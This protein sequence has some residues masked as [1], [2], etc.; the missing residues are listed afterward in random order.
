MRTFITLFLLLS[1]ATSA[2]PLFSDPLFPRVMEY[3]DFNRD[4]YFRLGEY[5]VV[6]AGYA[7]G[8]WETKGGWDV[9]TLPHSFNEANTFTSL[10][11]YY[12]GIG[13]Y[14][15]HFQVA[16]DW[17]S[18]Q[19][20]LRFGAAYSVADV[21]VNEVYIGR[22]TGGFTPIEADVTH[23]VHA[24]DNLV[25][26]KVSNAHDPD[27]LPGKDIPDYCL[28]GGLYREAALVVKDKL[29]IVQDG[30]RITT[31]Q[32]SE[33][34]ATAQIEV[35]IRNDYNERK[36]GN[37]MVEI[38]D[39]ENPSFLCKH[40]FTLEAGKETVVTLSPDAIQ[41]PKLWSLEEPKRYR[42]LVHLYETGS[43]SQ[44]DALVAPIDSMTTQAPAE[45]EL[46]RDITDFGFRWFEFKANEGFFLNGKRVK[47][48]GVNRHQD[49]PGLANALP[50]WM[51]ERDAR[52]IKEAGANF[53]RASHYPQHPAFLN[54]CDRLGILVYEEICSWQYVGGAKFTKNAEAM[55][56]AM[57]A[58]DI[59]HPSIIVWGLF[60][61][62]RSLDLFERLHGIAS[63]LD[64]ARPTVYAENSPD[65]GLKLGTTGVPEVLGL[66]YS[67]EKLAE[68]H[69]TLPDKPLFSSEYAAASGGTR[70]DLER[71]LSQIAEIKK[72]LDPI[73]AQPFMAGHTLWSMHDY[74]TDYWGG[75]PVHH[76]GV[77]DAWRLPK[78]G[79]F[80][81]QTRWQ[82]K[83]VVHICGHWTWPG[84]EGKTRT[85]TVLSNCP[86]VELFLNGT[87]L[88]TRT[89]ENPAQWE[90]PYAPGE[91]RAVGNNADLRAEDSLRTA[92]APATLQLECSAPQLQAGSA[93]AVEITA[94]VLDAAGV[95][96]PIN[97]TPVTF[98]VE[99]PGIL[100]GVGGAPSCTLEMGIGRMILQATS[101]PATLTV[102][103]V[104]PTGLVATSSVTVV[105]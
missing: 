40:P 93:D 47:L 99:T 31:P 3:K 48:Q 104:T 87:S 21:W 57:I 12:R 16:E 5:D 54:A 89:T 58:R 22:Y 76:S 90:V 36:N 92:G 91:L 83:P 13:W 52:M 72:Q 20:F 44:K 49:Y 15:K 30:I 10:R 96:V 61:E 45:K 65:E 33:A 86:N 73:E 59:N 94:K 6:K 81:M 64:P 28:Y 63:K 14:R 25:A 37:C 32:V 82:A 103:A 67:T 53:V 84:E 56:R 55:M 101:A 50:Q 102:K 85:V 98:S 78:D 62:G 39:G 42:V 29:H 70:K 1:A 24:G 43:A 71:Q 51:Q 60:N 88:G 74:S 4:W 26:V 9:V 27:V 68:I 38:A 77:L 7:A 34:E 100:R 17:T 46:D 11:G 97:D 80:Y 79:W 75:W 66:N 35:H 41:H 19:I 95:V 105:E 8:N 18:R 2:E 23:A 69:A